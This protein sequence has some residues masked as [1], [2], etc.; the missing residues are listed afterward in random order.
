MFVHHYSFSDRNSKTSIDDLVKLETPSVTH[1][2]YLSNTPFSNNYIH[3]TL[4]NSQPKGQG[5]LET[6][7]KFSDFLKE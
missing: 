3:D 6:Y 4:Q 1:F 7:P 2:C 5:R